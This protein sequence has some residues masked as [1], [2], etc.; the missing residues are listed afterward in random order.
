MEM[1]Q[2]IVPSGMKPCS[3]LSKTQPLLG[4]THELLLLHLSLAV[5]TL[6]M[7]FL[8]FCRRHDDTSLPSLNLSLPLLFSLVLPV[9]QGSTPTEKEG[10]RRLL[11]GRRRRYRRR[12]RLRLGSR[13][14]FW[15]AHRG[16]LV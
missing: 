3:C 1:S 13:L 5:G 9:A 15:P 7:R 6:G 8:V 14:I 2:E 10:K 16:L 12:L 11:L 4:S